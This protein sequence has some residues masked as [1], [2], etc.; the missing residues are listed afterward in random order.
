M[1]RVSSSNKLK[2]S[3]VKYYTQ[4]GNKIRRIESQKITRAS[5]PNEI[6]SRIY[7][8]AGVSMGPRYNMI[9]PKRP[10]YNQMYKRIDELS[11]ALKTFVWLEVIFDSLGAYYSFGRYNLRYITEV[12]AYIRRHLGHVFGTY[13]MHEQYEEL[14]RILRLSNKSK[15]KKE[16]S[17][18]L[19]DTLLSQ[20]DTPTIKFMKD[21]AERSENSHQW[22]VQFPHRFNRNN[23][24]V[25]RTYMDQMNRLYKNLDE[26]N[27]K[28]FLKDKCT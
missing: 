3:Q 1:K 14:Q 11:G 9:A 4:L 22:N 27:K 19:W 5:L 8:E 13:N 12:Q 15:T 25:Q 24:F 17:V 20:F 6:R 2:P 18:T 28:E 10:T 26:E 16:V 7:A 23:K 21:L